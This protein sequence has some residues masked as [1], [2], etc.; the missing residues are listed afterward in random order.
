VRV[1]AL[2]DLTVIVEPI[3]PRSDRHE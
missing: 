3:A 2:K 1:V